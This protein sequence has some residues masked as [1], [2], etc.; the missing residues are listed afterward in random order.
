MRK[1]QID[2]QVGDGEIWEELGS[3]KGVRKEGW[4]EK[5]KGGREGWRSER[6]KKTEGVSRDGG[7]RCTMGGM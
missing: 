3:R 2:G 6:G 4:E 5:G 1:K 7:H